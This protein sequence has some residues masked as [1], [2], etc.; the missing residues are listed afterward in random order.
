MSET[1]LDIEHRG[2]ARTSRIYRPA[3]LADDAGLVV[4]LH[5]ATGDGDEFARLSGF[6]RE[7]ERLGWVAAYP[8]AWNPGPFGGW[9][10]FACCPNEHDDVG[11][12]SQLMKRIAGDHAVDSIR[13]F[14]AGFSRG[15]MMAYR[16]GCELAD[17]VAG[18]AAVAGNMADPS[19][20]ADA[21]VCSPSRPVAVLVIHGTDDRVV[22]VE[23]GTSPLNPDLLGY[24]PL[25]DVVLRW[26]RMNRCTDAAPVQQIGTTTIRRWDGDA[27]VEL[28]LEVGG[29]HEWFRWAGRAIS[30]F[31]AANPK[32]P[33]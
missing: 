10:T 32:G 15:G 13:V 20:S 5:P 3:R 2:V 26:R 31:F 29:G 4:M 1:R 27:P 12:I 18:I 7:A 30:D 25:T 23:G 17:Q 14:V 8:D 28:R 33:G 24:A 22:P 19:G 16:I 11:F 6:D 21:V 9:D